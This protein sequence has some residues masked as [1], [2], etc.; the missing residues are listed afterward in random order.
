MQCW[1]CGK[2]MPDA[3]Q[4]C[5]SCEAAVKPKPTD[6]DLEASRA[7]MEQMEPEAVVALKA[8]LE[9]SE[10]GEEFVNAIMVGEC[11]KCGSTETGSCADDPEI[12]DVVD[13]CFECGQLW[14]T[15][16]RNL[17]DRDF[18]HCECWDE[19]AIDPWAE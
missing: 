4:H 11:P 14:C 8:K 2:D 6:E 17:I 18:V 1:S 9:Q 12:G 5:P 15:E 16:C 19:D 3:A 13:R 7:V 10:T